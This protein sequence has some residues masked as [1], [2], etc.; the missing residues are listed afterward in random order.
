MNYVLF[1]P[2]TCGPSN[3]SLFQIP[4]PGGMRERQNDMMLMP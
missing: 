3:L 4:C 2:L 1:V